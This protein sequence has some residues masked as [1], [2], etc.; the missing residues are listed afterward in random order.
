M[1]RI[2]RKQTKEPS[3][4][5]DNNICQSHFRQRWRDGDGDGSTLKSGGD[6]RWYSNYVE[7]EW[8]RCWVLT[9][10]PSSD[11]G[12]QFWP[13]A[14]LHDAT[15][16]G[17][18]LRLMDCHFSACIPTQTKTP[19]PDWI[20]KLQLLSQTVDGLCWIVGSFHSWETWLVA[21]HCAQVF[22]PSISAG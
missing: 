11:W 22:L 10:Q 3:M 8:C 1:I 2:V 17:Q 18:S 12:I 13:I 15:V 7:V 20:N 19:S 21:P 9:Y 6:H 16:K 14:M 5:V 4:T